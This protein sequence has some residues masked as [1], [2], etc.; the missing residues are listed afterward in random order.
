M[1]SYQKK[2]SK[3]KESVA[4]LDQ[5]K[6]LD[7]AA[8]GLLNLSIEL[9]FE[10]MRQMLE[11]DVEELAGKK[12]KHNP[13]RKAYRHGSEQTKVVLG[14]EKR[15]VDKPRVR[16][17]NGTELAIPCLSLFQNEDALSRAVLAKLFRG[18]STR[19][20]AGT[21]EHPDQGSACTSKSDVN[22][23]FIAALEPM[24]AQFLGRC[25]DDD[26][27][28]IMIDG[29][30][31]GEMTVL[32][33]MGIRK[34]GTKQM[35]GVIEGSSENHLVANALLID[36]IG[37]GLAADIPHLFVLDGGKALHKAVTDT[38]GQ[39]ATIQRCQ[40]HKKRNVLS[41]LPKSEQSNVSLALS[42]AYL[43]FDYDK[44]KKELTLIADNLMGRYP[45]AAA[46][47]LEGLEETLTVHRLAIPGLLRQ[48]LCSTNPMESANSVCMGIVRRIKNW[49]DGKMV[50]RN[51]TAG[52][53]EAEKS[54]RRIKGYR[55][56]P[57]LTSSLFSL[58]KPQ[59]TQ[60]Q[61]QSA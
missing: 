30:N 1:K 56:I 33:A 23:R 44:A 32:A 38:F 46:S 8:G 17:V 42:R 55:Q 2:E 36:L 47:L 3:V 21:L 35:L 57:V 5:E 39:F 13:Q 58:L 12:G 7:T 53:L 19:K 40:V 24:V 20:Y 31:I 50:L 25:L 28:A 54:F 48:T 14:G 4:I 18:V 37:R 45:T 22:R 41:H 34:D 60:G 43:E 49:K 27:P 9:G 6:L 59:L 11:L 26:Y 15:G 61:S 51:I 52:F 16:S 29:M 10:V